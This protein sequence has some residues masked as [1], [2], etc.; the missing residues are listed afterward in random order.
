MNPGKIRIFLIFSVMLNHPLMIIAKNENA[1][2]RDIMNNRKL[3]IDHFFFL[4]LGSPETSIMFGTC[5][6]EMED[7][8][9]NF[10]LF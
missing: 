10:L 7:L 5:E 6:V 2:V 8:W 3:F 1:S 4:I 9:K